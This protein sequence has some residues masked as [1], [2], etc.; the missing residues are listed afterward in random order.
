MAKARAITKRRRAVGNIRKVTRTMQLIATSQFQRS[1]RP[2]TA[3]KPFAAELKAMVRQLAAL[4]SVDHPLLRQ[5]AEA[6]RT[7][8]MVLTGNRGLCGGHNTAVLR[9]ASE[10]L[11]RLE[12]AGGSVALHVVGRKG[13][14]QLRGS[15]R[16]I[17]QSYVGFDRRPPFPAIVHI[18]DELIDRYARGELRGVEVCYTRFVSAGRQV[19]ATL[20]LLPVRPEGLAA[21]P[22]PLP[23]APASGAGRPS[24]EPGRLRASD[25]APAPRARPAVAADDYDYSPAPAELL[26]ELL[27]MLVRRELFQ[28]FLDAGLSEQVAR[29]VAMKSASESAEDMIRLLSRRH[30]RARQTQITMDLLDIVGGA[31]AIG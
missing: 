22:E 24:D 15:G 28:C 17:E 29:M 11:G 30:N 6:Q 2:A 1:L 20:Q 19:P 18:A 13:L 4:E 9:E 7:V 27:P 16:A 31:E 25:F 3:G 8:L 23:G 10:A 26:A 12:A 14:A 21:E 5:N